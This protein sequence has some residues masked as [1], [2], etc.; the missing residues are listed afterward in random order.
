[1][2]YT[3]QKLNIGL[4]FFGDDSE[5]QT[6]PQPEQ[7]PKKGATAKLIVE[8]KKKIDELTARVAELEAE[9]G[10]QA[11]ALAIFMDGKSKTE[12]SRKIETSSAFW[13]GLRHIKMKG[14]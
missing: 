8:Q 7:K 9:N 13:G 12:P 11:E 2:L 14:R 6:D 3:K 1:M 5:D 4:Q 10:E